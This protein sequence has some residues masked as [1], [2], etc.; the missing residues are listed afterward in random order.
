M[1]IS[2]AAAYKTVGGLEKFEVLA[3]PELGGHGIK[4]QGRVKGPAFCAP[5]LSPG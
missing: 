3:K 5:D 1:R 2:W 4:N